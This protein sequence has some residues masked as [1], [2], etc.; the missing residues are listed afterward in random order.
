MKKLL[1]ASSVLM[2]SACQ[3]TGMG[4]Q[5][6]SIPNGITPADA[7]L[8]CSQMQMEFNRLD[9][10]ITA[11]GGAQ[12]NSQITSAGAQ[13]ATQAAYSM[14]GYQNAGI[15]NGLA[16]LAGN[17]GNINSQTQQQQSQ[18]AQTRRSQLMTLAQ[19]KGCI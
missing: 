2:L 7:N 19:E 1:I 10:I 16:G 4:M 18:A 13:A 11:A 15:I 5:T 14:G 12:T 8:T 6:A 3:T 17:L 9:Q